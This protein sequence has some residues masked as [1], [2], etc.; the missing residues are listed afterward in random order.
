MEENESVLNDFYW[1]NEVTKPIFRPGTSKGSLG[2]SWDF[3]GVV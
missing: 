1:H 2:I 3:L